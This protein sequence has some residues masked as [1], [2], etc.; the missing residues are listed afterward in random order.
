MERMR[1]SYSKILKVGGVIGSFYL[2]HHNILC[3]AN[4]LSVNIYSF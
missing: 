3:F 4:H 1:K 2:L